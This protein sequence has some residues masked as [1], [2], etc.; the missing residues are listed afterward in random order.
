MSETKGNLHG[1]EPDLFLGESFLLILKVLE[2]HTALDKWHH[3]ID[4]EFILENEIH[5]Y[6]EWVIHGLQNIL[7]TFE[8][9]E[10][11]VLNDEILPDA[12]H[13]IELPHVVLDEIYLAER[14]LANRLHN[15]ELFEIGA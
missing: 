5:V 1:E 3:E 14:T 10:L 11:L 7:L 8:V 4:A 9:F 12:L 6:Q 15:L 13:C 2:D